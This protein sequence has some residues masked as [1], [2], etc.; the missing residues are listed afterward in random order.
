MKTTKIPFRMYLHPG[1]KR[2]LVSVEGDLSGIWVRELE[3]CW[4]ALS[5]PGSGDCLSVDVGGLESADKEGYG[6]LAAMRANG[7]TIH[8]ID[9]DSGLL[10]RRMRIMSW[11]SGLWS[12][13]TPGHRFHVPYAARLR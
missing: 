3:R 12:A 9:E 4:R 6:L 10:R 2:I 8:G 1:S 7:V 13:A 11:L 5:G